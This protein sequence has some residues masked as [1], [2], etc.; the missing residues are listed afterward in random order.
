MLERREVDVRNAGADDFGEAPVKLRIFRLRLVLHRAAVDGEPC[1]AGRQHHPP[2]IRLRRDVPGLRSGLQPV[3]FHADDDAVVGAKR[4]LRGDRRIA[5]G[6]EI[7]RGLAD[8]HRR[9]DMSRDR[10]RVDA[11]IEHAEAAGLPDPFLVRVPAPHVL[12]PDDRRRLDPRRGQESLRRFDGRRVAGMPACEQGH[13]PFRR[14]RPQVLDL[15][16]R[17]ARRLFHEHMLAGQK[18]GA[19]GVVPELR[20]HAQRYRVEVRHGAEHRF[21]AGEIGNAVHLAVPACRR[22]KAV[23]RVL[24]QRRQMLVAHDLADADDA[25]CDQAGRGGL[26]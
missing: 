3:Q 7:E 5:V 9:Q 15:A 19:R 14:Q 20:R 1:A 23:I 22:R 2:A 16:H 18:R 10:Q 24:C 17:R 11:G 8:E 21:Y 25:E 6:G 13:A 12:L 4:N 26:A